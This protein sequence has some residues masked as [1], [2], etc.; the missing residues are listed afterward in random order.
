MT[1]KEK[2]HPKRGFVKVELG[3]KTR[4]QADFVANNQILVVKVIKI[5]PLSYSDPP[6]LLDFMNFSD[7]L[8]LLGSPV[9]SGPKSKVINNGQNL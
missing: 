7:P 2:N 6:R 3:G 9:Y 1:F 4:L 5:Q 8:R